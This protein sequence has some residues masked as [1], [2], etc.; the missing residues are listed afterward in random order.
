MSTSTQKCIVLAAIGNVSFNCANHNQ[1]FL[2]YLNQ[3][4]NDFLIVETHEGTLLCALQRLNLWFSVLKFGVGL[5]EDCVQKLNASYKVGHQKPIAVCLWYSSSIFYQETV[6]S[7]N[8][9][10]KCSFRNH[11]NNVNFVFK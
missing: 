10:S 11:A 5:S 7:Q 8:L 4:F 9:F 6:W 2:L 3:Q 1:D